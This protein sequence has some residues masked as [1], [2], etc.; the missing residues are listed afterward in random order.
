M[1]RD[2]GWENDIFNF[3]Y[4]DQTQDFADYSTKRGRNYAPS[5]MRT[6]IPLKS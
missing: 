6:I 4:N 5:F 1:K 2:I 3:L